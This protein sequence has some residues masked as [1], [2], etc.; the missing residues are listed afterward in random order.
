MGVGLA[1]EESHGL[2]EEHPHQRVVLRRGQV[3]FVDAY[4]PQDVDDIVGLETVAVLDDKPD[5][6]KELPL[7]LVNKKFDWCFLLVKG[8]HFPALDDFQNLVVG[9]DLLLVGVS[10]LGLE[11]IELHAHLELLLGAIPEDLQLVLH[12]DGLVEVH[13]LQDLQ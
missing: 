1:E 13:P 2:K 11:S 6:V 4:K 8:D 3:D 9:S 7:F 12:Q 5:T 10:P